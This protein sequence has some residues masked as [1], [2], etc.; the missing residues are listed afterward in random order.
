MKRQLIALAVL[1]S[2]TTVSH[3]GLFGPS[4][5]EKRIVE[6]QEQNQKMRDEMQARDLENAKINPYEPAVPVQQLSQVN[7][8]NWYIM[9]PRASEQSV[10]VAGTATSS[11]LAMATQKAILDADTKLAFQMES[12]VKALIK[13]Y[14]NDLGNEIVENTELVARKVSAVT[15]NG[16]HQVDMQVTQEGK[17]F[18]VFVLM[19]F[20][21]G[22]A[23]YFAEQIR[24][25]AQKNQANARERA[26]TAELNDTLANTE[27]KKKA[28]QELE[29]AVL[30]TPVKEPAPVI[31]TA[32]VELKPLAKEIID[33]N[34]GVI[35]R[36]I[37]NGSPVIQPASQVDLSK[38]P[39]NQIS[40]Q[41]LRAEID[42]I[43]AKPNA[44]VMTTTLQ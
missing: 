10:F 41:K 35:I 30:S 38:L 14:Q 22:G 23:N 32:P 12:V 25:D 4:D 43:L 29:Q 7:V 39:H 5:E 37:T 44:V 27:A 18:R 2:I 15:V 16:H 11:T 20:P 31:K 9:P 26:T 42:A 28:E 19:R 17:T 8:P 36:P 34:T 40:D 21:L 24:K 13:S 33:P 1:A 6:L 3:A